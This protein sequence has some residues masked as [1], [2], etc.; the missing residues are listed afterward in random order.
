MKKLFSLLITTILFTGCQ[1]P[2][3]NPY[4]TSEKGKNIYY[5]TFYAQPKTLDPARAYSSDE[6]RIIC[7]IY[8]PPLQ[9]HYLIRPYKL[10]PL[11]TST[12]PHPRY[13]D[14]SG[15]LLSL[16][17]P[18]EKVYRTVYE[19]QIKK[20]V[21]YQNH[22]S[23]AKDEQDKFLYHNLLDKD[24]SKI[25]G[26]SDFKHTG[27]RELKADDY[28]YQI[29][30]IADPRNN[31]PIFPIMAKYIF[32]LDTLAKSL[33]KTLKEVRLNR[34]REAGFTYNQETDEKTNPIW[35]DYKNFSLPGVIKKNDYTFQIILKKKYPQILYWLSMPFF[36]PIPWEA[37]KFYS[38]GPL[39][40]K[41]ITLQS[42]PVGTGPFM[43]DV[44]DPNS[45]IILIKNENFH[46]ETYPEKGEKGDREAG[47]LDDRGKPLP[48][49]EKVVYKLEKESIPRWNK[50]IQGYYDS[51]GISSDSFDQAIS[52]SP[53]GLI[54]LTD[55]FNK[56]EINLSVSTATTTMYFAFNMLDPVVGGYT[57][58]KQKLRQAISIALDIEERIEI[59]ANGR[60][61]PAQGPIPPGIFGFQEGIDYT[62]YYI[63]NWD[64]SRNKPARKPIEIAKTLL[65]EAGYRNGIDPQTGKPLI[66]GFDNALTGP[67]AQALLKWLQKQFRKIGII[68][69]T[70]TTDYNRFQEKVLN[71]N[72]QFLSWGW[73]A[74]YPDPE[75]FLFLLYGPNG[76][77]KYGGENAA[78]YDNPEFNHL[79]KKMESMEN[80]PER[81]QIIRELLNIARRDSPWIWGFHPQDFLLYHKWVFNAKANTMANNTL[82]YLRIDPVIR[83]SKRIAWNQPNYLPIILFVG[84]LLIATLP[85]IFVVAR[86]RKA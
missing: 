3:N 36:S 63:Y 40:K 28:I 58:D 84:I 15:N 66:I 42:Y 61:I 67:E 52:F 79:F 47:C 12:I 20:G 46:K 73:N 27:T 44:F 7:Q 10:I 69:E 17:S 62:N 18:T 83:E 51:S 11:T 6:Y 82:K 65:S 23:F 22:P 25:Y 49:F 1:T 34:K 8:E 14:K 5:N 29:Y 76:K 54:Q 81:L 77:K 26:I 37:V 41:N 39:I 38:Q 2:L 30:R 55:Q 57:S 86:N 50:F 21:F 19:I 31:S 68:L 70:K 71:G 75:N 78:N 33:E 16:N 13:F 85:A 45:E 80:T 4:S 35:L 53:E 59:F 74:D 60:G 48:F 56:K 72:F 64:K 24:L 9:Y 43:I 32:G